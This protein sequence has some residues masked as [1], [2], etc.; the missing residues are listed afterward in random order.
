MSITKIINNKERRIIR[1]S[2]GRKYIHKPVDLPDS[3][4]P[5]VSLNINDLTIEGALIMLLSLPNLFNMIP[6]EDNTLI[7]I[8][9]EALLE[10]ALTFKIRLET[11]IDNE[12]SKLV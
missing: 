2:G 6:S 8:L 12:W 7:S 1:S 3:P 11:S 10:D 4:K 9:D 5:S